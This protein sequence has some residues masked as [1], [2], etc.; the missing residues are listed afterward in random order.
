MQEDLASTVVIQ[1]INIIFITIFIKWL[2]P[3]LLKQVVRG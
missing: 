3:D 2:I 1:I